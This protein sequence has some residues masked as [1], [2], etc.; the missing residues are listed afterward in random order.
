[1]RTS[2]PN[3]LQIIQGYSFASDIKINK[4]QIHES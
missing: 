3:V 4:I 2:D 1:M